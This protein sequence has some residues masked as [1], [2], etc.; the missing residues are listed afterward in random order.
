[1]EPRKILKLAAAAACNKSPK[2]V[3]LQKL[4]ISKKFLYD[5]N[6]WKTKQP[7]RKC[8]LCIFR[9]FLSIKISRFAILQTHFHFK[10]DLGAVPNY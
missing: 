5:I 4:L 10:D 2:L 6:I 1:M 8:F 7:P 3:N 9:K